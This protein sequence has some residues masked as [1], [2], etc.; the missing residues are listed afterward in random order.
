MKEEPVTAAPEVYAVIAEGP[1]Q[2]PILLELEAEHSSYNRAHE[3]LSRLLQSTNWN[4]G[5]VVRLGYEA[6]NASVFH[7]MARMQK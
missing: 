5:C 1:T 7:E 6:G 4:R 3:R 2:G